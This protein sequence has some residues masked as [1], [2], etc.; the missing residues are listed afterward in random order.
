MPQQEEEEDDSNLLRKSR[1]ASGSTGGGGSTGSK[2]NAGA[3]YDSF[4]KF[5]PSRFAENSP[6]WNMAMIKYLVSKL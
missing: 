2:G 6:E 3:I 1:R 4:R 5:D